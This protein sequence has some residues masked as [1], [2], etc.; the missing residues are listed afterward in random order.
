MTSYRTSW[1]GFQAEKPVALDRAAA[2]GNRRDTRK[3]E[4]RTMSYAIPIIDLT[5]YVA[6]R[7]GALRSVARQIHDALTSIGFFLIT[8]HDVPAGLIGR[9]FA[10]AARVHD[11]PCPKSW[12]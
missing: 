12:R 1:C 4:D 5:D 3:R 6:N 8:G 11:L 2:Q 7:P 9:T 10:E